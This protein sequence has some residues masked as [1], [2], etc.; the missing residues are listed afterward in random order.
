MR[1]PRRGWLLLTTIAIGVLSVA[2]PAAGAAAP[3]GLSAKAAAQI[4]AL[5]KVKTSLTAPEQKLDSRL[6]VALRQRT[7]PAITAGLPKLRMGL[8]VSKS[9][10]TEV[11]IRAR[12]VGK[13]LLSRLKALGSRVRDTSER[14]DTVRAEVP[15][16]ALEQIASWANVLRI[17]V[18]LPPLHGQAK[19]L[20]APETKQQAAARI[21]RRLRSALAGLQAADQGT[22]VSEGD[23]TH[24]AGTARSRQHVTGIGAKVCALSDGVASLAAE[25]AAG[26]LPDVDVLPGEE[27]DVELG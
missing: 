8:T 1:V 13:D 24:A 6:V 3:A 14:A 11:D 7:T 18:A 23:R 15:L 26:E 12:T 5:Q 17:D 16:A 21:D 10:S 27:G 19:P 22:I 20:V 25:Q 4:A 2:T 9:G